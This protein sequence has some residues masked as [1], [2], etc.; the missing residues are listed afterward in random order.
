LE[1]VV[2]DQITAGMIRAHLDELAGA[3]VTVEINSP[4]GLATE[5]L[6]IFNALRT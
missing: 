6:A 2:G 3:A 1:G 5:G 4:G